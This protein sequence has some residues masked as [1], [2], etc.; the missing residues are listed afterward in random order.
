MRWLRRLFAGGTSAT[1][2]AVMPA[3][4]AV[5]LASGCATAGSS[6]YTDRAALNRFGGTVLSVDTVSVTLDYVTQRDIASQMAAFARSSLGGIGRA[7]AEGVDIAAGAE[8]AAV[9]E[10]VAVASIEV[11]QRSFLVGIDPVNSIFVS[12]TATDGEGTV[13]FRVTRYRVGKDTLL[14]AAVQRDLMREI[15]GPVRGILSR[16]G[17]QRGNRPPQRES[18]AP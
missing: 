3:L 10:R 2:V 14:S 11:N 9:E 17:I 15:T 12:L 18:D 8:H 13:L 16:N 4:L 1:I 7:A 6:M 5:V